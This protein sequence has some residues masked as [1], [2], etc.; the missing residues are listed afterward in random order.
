MAYE[1]KSPRGRVR[2]AAEHL[3]VKADP[4]LEYMPLGSGRIISLKKMFFNLGEKTWESNV[5]E[6]KAHIGKI[7]LLETDLRGKWHCAEAES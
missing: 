2:I 4:I 6:P 3:K 5:N 1:P 7:L